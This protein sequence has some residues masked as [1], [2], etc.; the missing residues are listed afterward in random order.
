MTRRKLKI[1]KKKNGPD[2]FKF[3]SMSIMTKD[4]RKLFQYLNEVLHNKPG[5]LLLGFS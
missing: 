1:R 5:P 2:G 4:D 3:Q